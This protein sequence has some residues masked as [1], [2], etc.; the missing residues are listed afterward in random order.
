LNAIFNDIKGWVDLQLNVG[1]DGLPR[2]IIIVGTEPE[3]RFDGV[4]LESVAQYRCEPFEFEG[5]RS[6]N[7]A[8][9]CG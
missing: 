4:A 2:E 8:Q 6:M 1:T 3:R 7:A 5:M 9:I